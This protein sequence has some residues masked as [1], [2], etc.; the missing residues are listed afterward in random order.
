M[1]IEAT[2]EERLVRLEKSNKRLKA[3]MFALL[4]LISAGVILGAAS[5]SPKI[6]SAERFVLVDAA[7]NERAELSSNSKS[8][9]L[10]FLNSNGSKGMVL[11][12]GDAGNGLLVSDMMGKSRANFLALNDGTAS[13]SLMNAN[14]PNEAFSVKDTTQ[15][16]ALVVHD[17]NGKDRLDLGYT[18]KGASLVVADANGTTKAAVTEQGM[19]TFKKGGQLEWASF[20]EDMKPEERKHIRDLLNS[21]MPPQ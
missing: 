8:A 18:E 21:T 11:M 19:V 14:S 9:A 5:P 7:G 13:L 12:T 15:G 10:Q 6:L 3:G 4:V 1:S 2:A 20:G 16:T 17:G